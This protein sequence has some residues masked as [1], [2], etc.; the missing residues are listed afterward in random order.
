MISW[1]VTE[2]RTVENFIRV[3]KS[4]AQRQFVN[5]IMH[6]IGAVKPD[7]STC[8][9]EIRVTYEDLD[10]IKVAVQSQSAGIVSRFGAFTDI[11]LCD[12]ID[13]IA[14]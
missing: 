8:Q 2:E 7:E 6:H 5:N 3:D 11:L 9:V 10:K 12:E 4:I 13:L 14:W 1:L